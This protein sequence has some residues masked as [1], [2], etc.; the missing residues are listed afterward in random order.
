MYF[1]CKE[2]RRPTGRWALQEERNSEQNCWHG[3]TWGWWEWLTL[4]MIIVIIHDHYDY[5]WSH[6]PLTVAHWLDQLTKQLIG[7][8]VTTFNKISEKC[9]GWWSQCWQPLLRWLKNNDVDAR[10]SKTTWINDIP[11]LGCDLIHLG[12]VE[13][14]E[15]V[16]EGGE[17]VGEV[18]AVG[19]LH[20][21]ALPDERFWNWWGM[22]PKWMA[23]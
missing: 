19:G 6:H 17:V 22:L 12:D 10:T 15:Y 1:T 16:G 8:R 9:L 4:F 2:P 20:R 13:V 5:L 23:L 18:G 3:F 14:P 21:D 7:K 11:Y